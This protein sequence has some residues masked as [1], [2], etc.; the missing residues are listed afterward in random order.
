V[1][2]N[3][4]L[5]RDRREGGNRSA[6]GGARSEPSGPASPA[7]I[8]ELLRGYSRAGLSHVQLWLSPTTIAGL[9][10]FAAVLDLLDRG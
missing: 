3:L 6:A 2:L 5:T 8:A 10:W 1:V 4:P 7:E 9:E